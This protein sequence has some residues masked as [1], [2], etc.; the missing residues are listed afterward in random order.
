MILIAGAFIHV[1]RIEGRKFSELEPWMRSVYPLGFVIASGTHIF[2]GATSFDMPFS[3]G[4]IPAS[5]IAFGGG[6]LLT[7]LFR[8]MPENNRSQN[9]AA[10]G[11][12]GMSLFWQSMQRLMDMDWLIS[13]IQRISRVT[14]RIFLTISSVLE[15]NGGIIWEFLIIALLI[16]AAFSGG[17]L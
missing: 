8:F 5:C 9:A 17:F 11:R 1:L 10:W 4:V 12:A 3:L 6:V 15:D 16:A 7:L 14:E 13:F 2:I